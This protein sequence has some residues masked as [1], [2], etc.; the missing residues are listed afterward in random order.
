[1]VWAGTCA[2]GGGEN[3]AQSRE[4]SPGCRRRSTDLRNR[5]YTQGS[6]IWFHV[7]TRR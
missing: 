1:M 5:M 7:A 4:L 3:R 2:G 6:K